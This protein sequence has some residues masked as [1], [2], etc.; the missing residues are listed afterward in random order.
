MSKKHLNILQKELKVYLIRSVKKCLN[1]YR[2]LI[3][4]ITMILLFA[5]AYLLFRTDDNSFNGGLLSGLISGVGAII[6]V[7]FSIW[8]TRNSNNKLIEAQIKPYILLTSDYFRH[9]YKEVDS[10]EEFILKYKKGY[11]IN[12]DESFWKSYT[13]EY[14][15]D[16]QESVNN[17]GSCG[18]IL[19]NIGAAVAIDLKVK[20]KM[21]GDLYDFQ[22]T[23]KINEKVGFV[24]DFNFPKSNIETKLI[25]EYSSLNGTLYRDEYPCKVKKHS[26]RINVLVHSN[27]K[28]SD[29]IYGLFI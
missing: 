7:L 25:I 9:V 12:E 26:D 6:A 23:L 27:F 1:K 18:I 16:N 20:I 3:I 11:Q 24:L 19:E 4:A 21:G 10:K 22:N 14:F 8:F 2:E 28:K 13:G 17:N 5:V 15:Y 29:I